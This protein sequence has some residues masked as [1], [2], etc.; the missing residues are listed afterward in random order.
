MGIAASDTVVIR[1]LH[2]TRRAVRVKTLLVLLLAAPA[3]VRGGDPRGVLEQFPSADDRSA[4][5]PVSDEPLPA[6]AVAR[7]G[8]GRLRHSSHIFCL[9]FSPDGKHL[10]S[11]GGDCVIRIWDAATGRSLRIL[12]GFPASV[13]AVAFSPDGA[14]L[15]STGGFGAKAR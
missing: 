8:T 2:F 12:S 3:A 6:G 9:D 10:A 1:L 5:P 14:T 11:A 15:A 13:M 7:L 4:R